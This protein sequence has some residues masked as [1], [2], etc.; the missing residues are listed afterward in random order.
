VP[1]SFGSSRIRD[2]H[3]PDDR[4][5]IIELIG[6]EKLRATFMSP[7]IGIR[8]TETLAFVSRGPFELDR[9]SS[10]LLPDGQR[11]YFSDLAVYTETDERW[12]D[13][14]QLQITDEDDG[15]GL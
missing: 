2:W 6:R 3:A 10:V 12:D 5:L 7:C 13:A 4:T 11:C 15:G 14:E 1:R 9:Y 8:H